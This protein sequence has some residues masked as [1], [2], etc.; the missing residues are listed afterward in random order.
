MRAA[1]HFFYLAFIPEMEYYSAGLKNIT[2]SCLRFFQILVLARICF[3]IC[4]P[5]PIMRDGRRKYTLQERKEIYSRPLEEQ[6]ITVY[7]N[8]AA[9]VL[10]HLIKSEAAEDYGRVL[11][12]AK[13]LAQEKN[14]PVFLLPEINAQEKTL[15]HSLGL[16]TENG[17]TPDIMIEPGIFIDV[18]SPESADKIAAN[19]CKAFRQ[20]GMACITDHAAVLKMTQI[21]RYSKWI[22]NS[23]GY[24]L[25]DVYFFIAGSLHKRTKE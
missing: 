22:L 24:L 20:G 13:A 12:V 15:R 19:A 21:D 8:G 14:G 23:Q 10:K 16:S 2:I 18:K 17:K 5:V 11:D 1:S 3:H 7:E 25:N 4:L 6:F 9:V